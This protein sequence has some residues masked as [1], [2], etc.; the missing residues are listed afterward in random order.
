[1]FHIRNNKI[2]PNTADCKTWG[3]KAR[4]TINPHQRAGDKVKTISNSLRVHISRVY[5]RGK[6]SNDP[7]E[8][9]L[10]Q[11]NPQWRIASPPLKLRL[12]LFIF[13]PV[14]DSN[15]HWG[16]S[17]PDTKDNSHE[18]QVK[19]TQ[20]LHWRDILEKKFPFGWK[21]PGIFGW[22]RKTRCTLQAW[23]QALRHIFEMGGFLYHFKIFQMFTSPLC[24]CR[25]TPGCLPSR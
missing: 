8:W 25:S 3:E 19:G 20:E 23:D 12:H 2:L 10:P 18:K 16:I 5:L 4:A 15:K 13:D 14:A 9:P 17:K 21:F 6:Y 7:W 22:G 11:F 24:K 1:M